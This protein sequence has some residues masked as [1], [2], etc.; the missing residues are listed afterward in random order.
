M[1]VLACQ[2]SIIVILFEVIW[3][4]LKNIRYYY[5]RKEVFEDA[6]SSV[7]KNSI[8]EI[9]EKYN[10]AVC[11]ASPRLYD[12]YVS[13]Y[14]HNNTQESLSVKLG[15]TFETISRLNSQLLKFLQKQLEA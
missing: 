15:Y 1:I 6:S 9:I 2:V 13:L 12:I 8:T 7:G 14:L 11:S 5:S 10:K 3:E 4:D